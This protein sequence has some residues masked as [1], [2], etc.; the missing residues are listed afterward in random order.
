MQKRINRRMKIWL[1]GCSRQM[2]DQPVHNKPPPSQKGCFSKTFLQIILAA[3][4][5]VHPTSSDDRCLPFCLNL[6]LSSYGAVC[7][8]ILPATP[9]RSQSETLLQSLSWE[10][11][12]SPVDTE[13]KL[14]AIKLSATLDSFLS[15]KLHKLGGGGG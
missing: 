5:Y 6:I 1:N 7:C 8:T 10:V 2:D 15:I 14:S 12:K 4:K 9:C 11:K 13:L 3:F